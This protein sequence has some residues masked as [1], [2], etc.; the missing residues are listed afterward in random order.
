MGDS[1]VLGQISVIKLA[2]LRNISMGAFLGFLFGLAF[3]L[4]IDSDLNAEWTKYGTYGVTAAVSLFASAVALYG[5]LASIEHQ[6][7]LSER[8]KSQSL[9]ASR[10]MLPLALTQ[11]VDI[12]GR[13]ISINMKP[14]EALKDQ[15][16]ASRIADELEINEEI[17][18]ILKDC[19]RDSEGNAHIWLCHI[20]SHYQV[21]RSRTNG[22]LSDLKA[23][24]V[25][26]ERAKLASDWSV[27]L[28]IVE[29]LFAYSR[30]ATDAPE[31]IDLRL[32][33][34]STSIERADP[35]LAHELRRYFDLLADAF[36]NGTLRDF[37]LH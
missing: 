28:C 18:R 32:P 1:Q 5:I 36:G 6:S 2:G 3:F 29:H 14:I 19:I 33:Y 30:G 9:A 12:A 22:F 8:Q 31:K 20:V 21:Y 24:L 35:E 10:A 17:T 7:Y 23:G 26:D 4:F 15:E 27:F 11:L 34:F 16:A 37:S 25:T 13:A